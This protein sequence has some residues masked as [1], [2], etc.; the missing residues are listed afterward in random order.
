MSHGQYLFKMAFVRFNQLPIDKINEMR[1][2]QKV[3]FLQDMQSTK[4]RSIVRQIRDDTS[5][6]QSYS[7]APKYRLLCRFTLLSVT[8]DEAQELYLKFKSAIPPDA[9]YDTLNEERFGRI[10]FDYVPAWRYHQDL[11]PVLYKVPLRFLVFRA[12]GRFIPFD[13]LLIVIIMVLQ[14]CQTLQQG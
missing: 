4:Q 1:N 7:L 8:Q 10:F 2:S 6:K 14:M 5:C 9:T 3:N 11:L 12:T 13:R